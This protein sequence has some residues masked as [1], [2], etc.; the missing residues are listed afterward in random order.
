MS[1]EEVKIALEVTSTVAIVVASV[2]AILGIN[3]WR[4]EFHGKRNIELAEEVLA[5]FY[6]AIDAVRAIRSSLGYLGEGATR[7]P[8]DGETAQQKKARDQAY[9]V[10]ARYEKR[11]EVFN[12]LHSKRYQFMARF[13]IKKAKP[14]EDLR[15]IVIEIQVSANR[16]ADI[17]SLDERRSEATEKNQL[18]HESVIW[19]GSRDDPIARR[20]EIVISDIEE[21]CEPMILGKK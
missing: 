18:E 4:K 12:R 21:I 16:L 10:Y 20:L 19:D 7:K 3:A 2:V 15:H 13:G 5:L 9:V 8:Q 14:F 17:W 6:E 11:Q 1:G